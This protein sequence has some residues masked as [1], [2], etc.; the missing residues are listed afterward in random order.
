MMRYMKA[1][2]TS[3]QDIFQVFL[4]RYRDLV[5]RKI[6]SNRVTLSR[7][8]ALDEDPFPRPLKLG[9]NTVAWDSRLVASWLSRRAK[10]GQTI[11]SKRLVSKTVDEVKH[12]A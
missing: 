10:G 6:V 4:L 5:E 2:N 7:W 8:M 1:H 3:L 11:V 9:P 12:S